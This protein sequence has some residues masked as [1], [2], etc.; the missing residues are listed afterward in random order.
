MSGA[1]SPEFGV[2]QAG[3]LASENTEPVEVQVTR[4]VD[5]AVGISAGASPDRSGSLVAKEYQTRSSPR[6]IDG[7]AIVSAKPEE[8]GLTSGGA[9]AAG[10]TSPTTSAAAAVAANQRRKPLTPSAR[11]G[12]RSRRHAA[13]RR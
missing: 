1:H 3:R 11:C 2:A 12:R 7:S 10:P 4:S 6:T 13:A 9:A 5:R 8:T